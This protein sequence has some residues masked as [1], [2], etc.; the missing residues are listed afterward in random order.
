MFV[1]CR[2]ALKIDK[3]SSVLISAS[4]GV[5]VMGVLTPL[6]I[7]TLNF[8]SRSILM[9]AQGVVRSHGIAGGDQGGG[10]GT[11]HVVAACCWGCDVSRNWRRRRLRDAQGCLV[12]SR[13][14]MSVDMSV[15]GQASKAASAPNGRG[16]S[17]K[18]YL[19]RVMMLLSY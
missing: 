12:T 17:A 13:H 5:A 3:A 9:A 11:Q 10:S 7:V 19:N 6:K 2:A 8:R 1:F 16:A 14:S 18:F 15:D 4:S